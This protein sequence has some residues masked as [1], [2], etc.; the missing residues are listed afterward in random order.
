MLIVR[1]PE[2]EGSGVEMGRGWEKGWRGRR[3]QIRKGTVPG[4]G[5][6]TLSEVREEPMKG[7]E[8]MNELSHLCF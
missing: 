1:A 3:D 7:F 2:K 5:I 4:K 8:H 6:Q